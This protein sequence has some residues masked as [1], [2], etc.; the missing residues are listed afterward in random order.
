MVL[1]KDTELFGLSVC[2]NNQISCLEAYVGL[3]YFMVTFQ[4]PSLINSV[5]LFSRILMICLFYECDKR[6]EFIMHYGSINVN[7]AIE[8]STG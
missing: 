8:G 6:C 3:D 7:N 5:K 1:T 2:L 4:K